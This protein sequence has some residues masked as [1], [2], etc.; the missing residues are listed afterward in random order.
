MLRF[1][2]A[3]ALAFALLPST[4]AAEIGELSSRCS[5]QPTGAQPVDGTTATEAQMRSMR[6]EVQT[7]VDA[8]Q[9]FID[10]VTLYADSEDGKKLST[11][12]KQRLAKLITQ[13][14]DEKEEVGCDFQK[15]LDAYNR[16]NGLKPVEFDQVCIDRFAKQQKTAPAPKTP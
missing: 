9:Q 10:C 5:S 8:S 4:H 15:Q 6:D 16:R 1:L 2:P 14:A 7:F 3:L 12:D 11:G 13:V